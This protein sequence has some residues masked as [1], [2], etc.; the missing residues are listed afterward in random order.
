MVGDPWTEKKCLRDDARLKEDRKGR[1]R[2]VLNVLSVGVS[3]WLDGPSGR[4]KSVTK[5]A[6]ARD[7]EYLITQNRRQNYYR[8]KMANPVDSTAIITRITTLTGRLIQRL[9]ELH[10]F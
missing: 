7:D 1:P 2:R 8:R 10:S 4:E 6:T 9:P 3:C 5:R